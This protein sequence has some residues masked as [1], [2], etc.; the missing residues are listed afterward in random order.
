MSHANSIHNWVS[1]HVGWEEFDRVFITKREKNKK[2]SI[3][4]HFVQL[5]ELK[6]GSVRRKCNSHFISTQHVLTSTTVMVTVSRI[7]PEDYTDPINKIYSRIFFLMRIIII[8]IFI[9]I[10]FLLLCFFGGCLV[11]LLFM[12]RFDL[13]LRRFVDSMTSSDFPN[14]KK[15]RPFTR[16]M[17]ENCSLFNQ[18]SSFAVRL[19]R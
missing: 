10:F 8:I 13:I 7:N 4:N 2:K 14:D 11:I 17:I 3:E 6:V 15:T 12:Y 5:E 1:I 16:S 18:A 9:F 19:V